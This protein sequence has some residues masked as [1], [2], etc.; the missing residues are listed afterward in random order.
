[1]H[2][3]TFLL[4]KV[5]STDVGINRANLAHMQDITDL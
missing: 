4:D 2:C 1:M 3:T 5:L